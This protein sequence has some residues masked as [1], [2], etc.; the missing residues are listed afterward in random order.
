MSEQ[1]KKLYIVDGSGYIFRAYYARSHLSTT[2]GFPTGALFGFVNMLRKLMDTFKPAYLAVAFDASRES[3]RTEMYEQYKANRNAP[4]DELALQMPRVRDIVRAN[5]IPVLEQVGVE[6]DD[7][8]A[9]MVR[10]ANEAGVPVVIISSDKDLM[11]LITDDVIMIDTMR[12]REFHVEDVVERFQVPPEQVADVLGLAGDSSDNIP[13]V[14]GIGEKTAG[15]LIKEFGSIENLL[16]N[17]EKVG[18]KK[19]KENLREYGAQ[20]LLSRKLVQLKD[21]CPIAFDLEKLKLTEPDY[22]ELSGLYRE[23]EFFSLLKRLAVRAD[24]SGAEIELPQGP[25]K[26]YRTILTE[27]ELDEAIA[28]MRATDEA[29]CVD[30]ETTSLNKEEALIVGLALA[31]EDHKGVYVPVNHRY[32]VPTPPEQLP[33]ERVL[34]KLKPLLEDPAVKKVGQNVKFDW[35][36]LKKRGIDMQGVVFDTMLASYLLDSSKL[37]HGLDA[38]AAEELKYQVVSYAELVGKGRNKRTF[39]EVEVERATEYAAED[40][41]VTRLLHAA[42]T[43][44]LKE[45]GLTGLMNELEMPLW[46][47]LARMEM[48]GVLVDTALLSELSAQYA[49]ELQDLEKQIHAA[50]GQEFNVDSPLQLRKILFDDLGLPI[51]KK[52]KTGPSTAHAVLEQLQSMHPLPKL[53]LEYRSFAKLKSTYV[54]ALPE[55]VARD[56]RIHTDFNQAVAATGRLSS[57]NPNLQN[58]PIRTARGREIRKAFIAPDG[59]SLLAADYSQIELRILA[60]MSEDE[61]LLDAFTRGQDIHQRTAAEIFDVAAEEVTADQRRAGKTINFGVI[62]GM[63]SR[64]L[65]RSLDISE[66]KAQRYIDSYFER[67]SGVRD[68]FAGVL[69]EAR[70]SGYASTLFDRRRPMSE[71]VSPKPNIR[72]L[73]ERLAINTPIQGT[74]ADVIKMAMVRIQQRLDDGELDARMLLQVHDELV[75]EVRDEHLEALRAMVVEEMSGVVDLKVPLVVDVGVGKSWYDAK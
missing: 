36:L 72:A 31:W 26:A 32:L 42:Y 58:I 39:D 37:S 28:A 74:A 71:L 69:E 66:D 67:Y 46:R 61:A 63:G 1:D 56:G 22:E 2:Q 59:W 70:R 75:F 33:L 29:I 48:T 50:A 73:G 21:D 14:P 30:L 7:L 16:D 44:K 57:S 65:A 11:Q 64:R 55:L 4:P 35:T 24:A 68:Y 53:I 34:E 54:D 38:L 25:D 5:R 45:A 49:V 12:D 60:H 9:T 20:A 15:K 10:K 51:I 19:R 18:G 27:A 17:I 6:A 43:P 13:G 40:A 8:I 62:Y 3:F 41:D 47:I 23:F 52:T